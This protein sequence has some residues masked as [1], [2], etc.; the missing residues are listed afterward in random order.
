M[1]AFNP[2]KLTTVLVVV[3]AVPLVFTGCRGNPGPVAD[4]AGASIAKFFGKHVDE[5]DALTPA[6][7][8]A[9]VASRVN[10]GL[11]LRTVSDARNAELAAVHSNSQEEEAL[12]RVCNIAVDFSIPANDKDSQDQSEAVSLMNAMAGEAPGNGVKQWS[13]RIVNAYQ[14]VLGSPDAQTQ[15]QLKL[16]RDAEVFGFQLAYCSS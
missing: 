7:A 11:A 16:T 10:E 3:V 15:A 2:R 12:N 8:K 9:K 5:L 6:T 13:E 14:A 4:A 1:S